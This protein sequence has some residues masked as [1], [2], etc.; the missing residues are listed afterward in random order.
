[1]MLMNVPPLTT[2][3]MTPRPAAITYSVQRRTHRVS[4]GESYMLLPFK[5]EEGSQVCEGDVDGDFV[6]TYFDAEQRV[7][8][9]QVSYDGRSHMPDLATA[10]RE[11]SL[12]NNHGEF[13]LA[14]T[15]DKQGRVQSYV[16]VT[17]GIIYEQHSDDPGAGIVNVIYV[18]DGAP[19]LKHARHLAE[20][21]KLAHDLYVELQM[22]AGVASVHAR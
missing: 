15:L 17:N 6:R 7:S 11:H 14:V 18:K 19:V 13:S 10:V 22:P 16:D 8:L 4:M 12:A 3:T 5:C 1:M 2:T 9:L 20:V 21:D